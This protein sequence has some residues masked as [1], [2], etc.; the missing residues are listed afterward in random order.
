MN[1]RQLAAQKAYAVNHYRMSARFALAVTQAAASR[2][3]EVRNPD[4]NRI[5]VPTRF[6]ARWLQ[7]A[8][9]TAAIEDSLDLHKATGFT[10]VDSANTVTP[11]ASSKV[12]GQSASAAQLRHVTV[13]GAAA[14][15]TGGTIALEATP[16]AQLP[17][18][19]LLAQPTG[20]FVDPAQLEYIEPNP[21]EQ[22][23]VLAQNE[24]LALVNRVLLGAAAGSSVYIDFS[25]AELTV[26]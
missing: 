13:A 20:G 8:A 24:G 18:W 11:V 5:I 21:E 12:T 10:A 3:F 9:H 7:T 23:L 2:L 22:P 4:A 25:W 14:G 26:G 6:A 17:Q 1:F 16:Q 19:L 15:M